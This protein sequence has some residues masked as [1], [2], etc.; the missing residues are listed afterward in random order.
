[1]A[2]TGTL[3]PQLL[4]EQIRQ[5]VGS[6]RPSKWHDFRPELESTGQAPFALIVGS[7]FSYGVVPFVRELMHE[8]IGA[9]EREAET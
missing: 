2:A 1:M 9:F 4:V 3:S 6:L 8:T 7:G 5:K